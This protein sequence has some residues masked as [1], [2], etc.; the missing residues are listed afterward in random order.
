MS[1]RL[2]RRSSNEQDFT[3]SSVT[4]AVQVRPRRSIVR[5]LVAREVR[6]GD[7]TPMM[8]EHHYLHSMPLATILSF[9]VFLENELVGGIVLTAGARH[10]H[11]IL[12]GSKSADVLTLARLYLDDAIPKNAE[13]RVLGIVT[14]E[15]RRRG[16]VKALLSHADPAVGHCGTIYKA[17]GWT[18]LGRGESTRYLDFGDGVLRHP[19]SVS[20]RYGTCSPRQLARQGVHATAVVTEGKH[21]FSYVLDPSW[22]WRLVGRRG[23]VA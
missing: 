11:R 18:Y 14:R 15:V 2:P 16:K 8:M 10:G 4:M 19:R 9:G 3:P 6:S 17:A 22:N 1:T 5:S 23:T 21:R 7:L 12:A 13:S 20:T